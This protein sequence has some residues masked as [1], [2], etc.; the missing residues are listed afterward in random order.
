MG[1]HYS[2]II[3]MF[4]NRPS[5]HE[6]RNG[7]GETGLPPLPPKPAKKASPN[8]RLVPYPMVAATV[9]ILHSISSTTHR[10]IVSEMEL[11]HKCECQKLRQE[12]ILCRGQ[13]SKIRFL[14]QSNGDLMEQ[15][16][17]L[18][19]AMESKEKHCEVLASK[20]RAMECVHRIVSDL[21]VACKEESDRWSIE[22]QTLR[23]QVSNL[24][25]T[26]C[27]LQE[28]GEEVMSKRDLLI[29]SLKCHEERIEPISSQMLVRQYLQMQQTRTR[30]ILT[31]M[32][33]VPLHRSFDLSTA[34]LKTIHGRKG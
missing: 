16:A 13:D 2:R 27:R 7:D 11:A 8:C 12:A 25:S 9:M 18:T 23:D 34:S 26:I 32:P 6:Q 5:P 10:R 31:K 15:K 17:Q 3:A 24:D 30:S 19:R 22:S 14:Q 20:V 4:T 29:D 28:S 1:E 33:L 21:K